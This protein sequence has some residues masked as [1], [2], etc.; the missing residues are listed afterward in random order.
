MAAY[1]RLFALLLTL[2]AVAPVLTVQASAADDLVVDRAWLEDPAA[3]LSLA[4]VISQPFT[5]AGLM[6]TRGYTASAHWLRVKVG[7]GD[8]SPVVLRV[9]PTYLDRV[10][11]HEPDPDAPGQ[12]RT[13]VTG[14]RTPFMERD[15]PSAALGF[16]VRPDGPE[17]TYYLRL[18][19]ASTSLLHVEALPPQIAALRDLRIDVSEILILGLLLWILFWT[20]SDFVARRDPVVG[21]FAVNQLFFISYNVLIMGYGA[22][23]FP[24]APVGFVDKLTSVVVIATPLFSLLTNRLLLRQFDLHPIARWMLNALIALTVVAMG[25]LAAGLTLQAL[26][27]NAIVVALIVPLLPV[28][29]FSTRREAPPGRRALWIVY[30][31]QAVSLFLTMLPLLGLLPATTWNLDANIIHGL[32]SDLPMFVLL[33]LRSRAERQRGLEA[34]IGLDL[35]RRQLELQRT[36]FDLQNRF[37]AMLTHELRT[38]L[39]VI[40]MAVGT[41]KVDGEPRQLIDDAFRNMADIIDRCT[42]ADRMDQ[43]RLDV[44]RAPVDVGSV[45]RVVIGASPG[46][47]RVRLDAEDLPELASDAQLIKVAVQNLIDN[48]LKYSPADSLIEVS[49]REEAG[50]RGPGVRI[51]VANLCGPAGTPDAAQVFEKFYRGPKARMKSGSGLGLYIVHGIATLLGGSV[52]YEI[53]DERARF[54]LWLPCL[55]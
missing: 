24:S 50:E 43:Q 18:A 31:I 19:T 32:L 15:L 5:P 48:A 14:D 30:M 53:R 20:A 52:S 2:V 41:A 1:L 27:L 3:T 39:S 40:R 47:G 22:L 13:R 25:L 37:M 46:A 26:K 38:P 28:L 35:T 45:L 44:T 6:L 16:T 33:A 9:R 17:T 29:A 55:V 10:E 34:Q 4:D 8:G 11:L 12:W 7:P 42:F 51:A 21:C 36:Q 49:A 54:S 23:I